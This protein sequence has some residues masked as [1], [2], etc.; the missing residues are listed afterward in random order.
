M[1]DLARIHELKD[2]SVD[3]LND[4]DIE[5]LYQNIESRRED[6]Q[7]NKD[8]VRFIERMVSDGLEWEDAQIYYESMVKNLGT[9]ATVHFILGLLFESGQRGHL[10]AE[11]FKHTFSDE[12]DDKK[13]L[14]CSFN[15]EGDFCDWMDGFIRLYSGGIN[16]IIKHKKDISKDSGQS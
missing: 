15:G 9:E 11:V 5:I 10:I 7:Y 6:I 3:S 2:L 13:E 16:L 8:R 1:A 12:E 14:L 4:E